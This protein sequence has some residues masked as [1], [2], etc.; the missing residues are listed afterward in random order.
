MSF[1]KF[2]I[3]SSIQIS[4]D[5]QAGQRNGKADAEDE[6][7][8]VEARAVDAHKA[9]QD[10]REEEVLQEHPVAPGAQQ[11]AVNQSAYSSSF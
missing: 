10:G 5:L 2:I 6:E 4:V 7:A 8:A 9:R 3:F 1:L 11:A